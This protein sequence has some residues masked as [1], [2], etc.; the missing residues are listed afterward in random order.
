[1]ILALDLLQQE[2]A[3]VPPHLQPVTGGMSGAS[4]FRVLLAGHPP[5]FLKSPPMMLRQAC[6]RKSPERPGLQGTACACPVF[7]VSTIE[8]TALPC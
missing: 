3:G 7:C 4:V 2:G 6:G 5:R 8:A 1:M